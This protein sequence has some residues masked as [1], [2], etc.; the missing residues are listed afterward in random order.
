MKNI[1]LYLAITT[2]LTFQCILVSCEDLVEVDMPNNQI[3]KDMV[4]EDVQTAD[5]ALAGLYSHLWEDSPI[6]GGNRGSGALLGTYT[7]DLEC[8][9]LSILNADYDLYLNQQ[10]E[11]NTSIYALWSSAYQK[12]YM[13]NAI[14]S[15]AEKSVA[16]STQQKERVKAEGLLARSILFFYLQQIFGDIPYVTSTDYQVNK[17]LAKTP[18]AEVLQQLEIDLTQAVSLLKDEYRNSERI[19]PNRKVAELLLAKIL[20]LQNKW[21]Q[22][23]ILLNNVVTSPLYT[24]ENNITKVFQ[25][26][27]MHI[28]WQLKPR[29]NGDTTKEAILYTFTNSP[30]INYALSIDLMDE[31]SA[32]DLRRQNWTKEVIANGNRWHRP[33]KYTVISNNTTEYSIV[34]RL[35]EAYLLLAETLSRQGKIQEAIPYVNA[36]R[37]RANLAPLSTTINQNQLLDEILLENRKEFFAEMGHRFLDLK[38]MNALNSL[39]VVKPNW[40]EHHRL[41]PV[42]Q[43]EMLLNP[44]LRPQNNGY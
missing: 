43:K 15:G 8:F 25:K 31:L 9:S 39:S 14:I 37:Q 17:S 19:F 2:L 40:A 4:F 42:P 3:S 24:F 28:L 6:A 27:G 10:I 13:A 35:E 33:N 32:T 16:L 44:K 7:D 29:N 38:R 41:W 23:E 36:T 18:A 1:K 12:I 30:P 20:M 21:P 11:T 5:A 26:S 22:A 34:F